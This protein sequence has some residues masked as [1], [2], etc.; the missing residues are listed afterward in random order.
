MNETA[1]KIAV[2]MYQNSYDKTGEEADFV[3]IMSD[4]K[5]DKWKDRAE[6]VRATT[7]EEKRSKLKQSLPAFTCSGIFSERKASGLISHSGRL[8]VDIDL[9]DN[10]RLRTD[11]KGVREVLET[12]KFTEYCA[13]SVSGKG[14]FVIV[15]ID[16]LKHAES[17]TF[18]ERYYFEQLGLV[19]DK[20]CKDVSRLRFIS[21]DPNLFHNPHAECVTVPEALIPVYQKTGNNGN[22]KNKEIM[23]TII[24]NDRLIGSD[25]Y[26]DWLRI[27]FAL[28][29]E[30]GE[31]GRSFFHELSRRSDKYD[32]SD[33]DRKFNNCL[34]NNQGKITFATLVKLARDAG[35]KLPKVKRETQTD[36]EVSHGDFWTF[37][38]EK[39]K[40]CYVV[41]MREYLPKFGFWRYQPSSDDSAYVY[42][43]ILNNVVSQIQPF[44][45]KDFLIDVLTKGIAS[46]KDGTQRG[47]LQKVL[48]LIQVESKFIFGEWQLNSLPYVE[49]DFLESTNTTGY[50]FF[51]NGFIEVTHKNAPLRPYRELIE[52]KKF[53]WRK[54][55]K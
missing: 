2:S 17:F 42:V 14:L 23:D 40:L 16:G 41:L 20:S 51:E 39:L 53:V 47:F 13:L 35:I 37:E 55:I 8:A 22:G 36:C 38:D 50:R 9:K 18:L 49:I 6:Q 3:Q 45:I 32:A 52:L 27:G 44:E 24:A 33:C 28:A 25:S 7:D 19:I 54:S 30:F 1:K 12:D 10:E 11:L 29:N 46:E 34:K 26:Q 48:T 43:R 15:R 21:Y 5:S 4:I 31:A